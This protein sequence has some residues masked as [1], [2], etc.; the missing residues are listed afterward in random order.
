[1]H[2]Q[3]PGGHLAEKEPLPPGGVGGAR[4]RGQGGAGV[5]GATPKGPRGL[6][7]THAQPQ[8]EPA[9]R[10]ATFCT[11]AM[12]AIV[13]RIPAEHPFALGVAAAVGSH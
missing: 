5:A 4:G 13:R 11:R 1:M 10:F 12:A 9:Q 6:L 2:F 7:R 3:L 8:P